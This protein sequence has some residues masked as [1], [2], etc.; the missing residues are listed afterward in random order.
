MRAPSHDAG[1]I[2]KDDRPDEREQCEKRL[3]REEPAICVDDVG[4][5]EIDEERP[6]HRPGGDHCIC[7]AEYSAI[8]LELESLAQFANGLSIVV[9]GSR[10]RRN[11]R[12]L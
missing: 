9:G 7:D 12:L 6:G 11:R 1:D 4:F 8:G 5:V 2:K 10:R 3:G